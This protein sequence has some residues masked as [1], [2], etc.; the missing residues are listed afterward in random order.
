MVSE[1]TTHSLNYFR[2]VYQETLN[3]YK[4][5]ETKAQ[6]VLTSNGAFLGY[7]FSNTLS[8]R[9]FSWSM[10]DIRVWANLILLLILVVLMGS[11]ILSFLSLKSRFKKN[12]LIE[13]AEIDNKGQTI[14]YNTDFIFFFDHLRH[15][16][17]DIVVKQVRTIDE[18]EEIRILINNSIILSKNV[19]VKHV[20][21]NYSFL[22]FCISLL[23]FSVYSV[24]FLLGT[25]K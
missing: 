18:N 6:I 1:A 13:I 7:L 12:D 21:V 5:A 14:L 11:I 20:C 24:V 16:K 23:L 8:K 22:L 15:M 17:T 19:K 10:P 2:N 3:W 4:S 9:D 25:G